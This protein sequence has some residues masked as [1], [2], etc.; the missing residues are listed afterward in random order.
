MCVR[1]AAQDHRLSGSVDRCISLLVVSSLCF[2][3]LC[4]FYISDEG[5]HLVRDYDFQF[6]LTQSFISV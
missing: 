3:N 1:G 2:I 6:M 5:L 4:L